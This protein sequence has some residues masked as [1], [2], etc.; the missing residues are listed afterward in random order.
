MGNGRELVSAKRW[1]KEE[2]PIINFNF[3]S[4]KKNKKAANLRN[5]KILGKKFEKEETYHI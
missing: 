3:L 5:K 4:K 1:K 2:N